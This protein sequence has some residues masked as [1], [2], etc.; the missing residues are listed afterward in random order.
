V[1]SPKAQPGVPATRRY[2]FRLTYYT[3]GWA[4]AWASILECSESLLVSTFTPQ[5]GAGLTG[6]SRDLSVLRREAYWRGGDDGVPPTL[7]S[8][9]AIG[10]GQEPALK[11]WQASLAKPIPLSGIGLA[12]RGFRQ[13]HHS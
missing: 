10:A 6:G 2:N 9:A 12:H 7:V 5:E 4:L 3:L 1:E 11:K 13:T 8:A